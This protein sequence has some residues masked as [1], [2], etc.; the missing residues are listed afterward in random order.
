M[1]YIKAHPFGYKPVKDYTGKPMGTPVDNKHTQT[2]T[3]TTT[4]N[5]MRREKVW[6]TDPVTGQRK[7]KLVP[8]TKKEG[9]K[10]V[11]VYDT[12]TATQTRQVKHYGRQ[13]KGKT[14]GEMVYESFPNNTAQ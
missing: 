2:V 3:T 1:A 7:M 12:Y 5:V 8:V 14:L 9:K 11:P 6:E 13:K 10:E 4:Y